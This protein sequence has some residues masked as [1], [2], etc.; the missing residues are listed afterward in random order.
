SCG[1]SGWINTS[2]TVSCTDY[3]VNADLSTGEQ[4]YLFPINGNNLFSIGFVS[5]FWMSNLAIGNG[6][7]WSIISR[8]NT[9]VRLDGFLNRS[10]VATTLPIIYKEV[11]VQQTHFVQISDGDGSDILRCRWAVG[12]TNN[13]NVYD[14]CGG[15]CHGIPGAILSSNNCSLTFTLNRSSIYYAVALQIEDYYLSTSSSPMS[16]VPIQFLI[17]SY[18]ASGG[19]GIPPAII[20]TRSNQDLY[21][22]NLTWTPTANQLGP[23]SFC[24][25]ALDNTNI[26]SD[27]WCIT[28]LVGFNSPDLIRPS[29]IQ[30]AVSPVGTI[31]ANRSLFTAMTTR[32]ITRPSHNDTFVYFKN[33]ANNVTA[34]SIDCATSSEI[35]YLDTLLVINVSN[36]SWTPGAIYYITFDDGAISGSAY[37]GK[38]L[39]NRYGGCKDTL[40][41]DPKLDGQQYRLVIW[42]S[43]NKFNSDHD[44]LELCKLLAPHNYNHRIQ[45]FSGVSLT[46]INI[47]VV[48]DNGGGYTPNQLDHP[49]AVYVNKHENLYIAD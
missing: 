1:A 9:F 25:A 24:A 44:I 3:S 42:D 48:G 5:G 43:M 36:A 14:E 21:Q 8:V 20:G 33:L 47:T 29:L 18:V 31:F 23:Q 7:G 40:S 37:C 41:V 39:H 35:L 4:Y 34:Y 26:S 13:T 27:Q 10:P 32:P 6:T 30:G 46:N 12:T 17:Y 19:C 16:S 45:K 22:I 11:N 49:S 15:I 2:T 38:F 28:F